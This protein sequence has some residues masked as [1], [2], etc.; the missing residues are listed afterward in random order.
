MELPSEIVEKIIGYC[1]EN[2]A[3][4]IQWNF[5]E[6]KKL[7]TKFFE[8]MTRDEFGFDYISGLLNIQSHMHSNDFYLKFTIETSLLYKLDRFAR[9]NTPFQSYF[10]CL[11]KLTGRMEM[12]YGLSSKVSDF[13]QN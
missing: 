13:W 12:T 3:R 7:E 9:L 2:A 4:K 8:I 5:R 1:L 6:H 10:D 11:E